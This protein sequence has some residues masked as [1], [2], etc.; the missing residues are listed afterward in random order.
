MWWVTLDEFVSDLSLFV[1]KIQKI[2]DSSKKLRNK[3]G[4]RD[5]ARNRKKPL[6]SQ[7]NQEV[8]FLQN[9]LYFKYDLA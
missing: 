5:K 9:L 3:M 2:I 8:E 4:E 1:K 6:Q 7:I